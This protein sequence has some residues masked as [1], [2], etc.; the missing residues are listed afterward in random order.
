[1]AVR[2]EGGRT[3][4]GAS[5]GREGLRG[6]AKAVSFYGGGV[7]PKGKICNKFNAFGADDLS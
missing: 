3:A 5:G 1:M 4:P 2:G 6:A 7:P